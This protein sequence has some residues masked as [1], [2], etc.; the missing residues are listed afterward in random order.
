[1]D[2]STEGEIKANIARLT[3][4]LA[5]ICK[6]SDL[7]TRPADI[8]GV[9]K[10]QPVEKIRAAL[11]AGLRRFGENR[12]Q[13][14]KRHWQELRPEFPDVELHLIG[15]LQS[16]KAADAVALFDVIQT[17]DR[18]KIADAIAAECTRQGKAVRCMVQVNT[19]EEE[20]K[21]GVSPAEANALIRYCR[22][23]AKLDLIGLMCVPPVGEHPAPHFGLLYEIAWHNGLSE[24]SMGMSG[25]Y[26][27]AAQLGA[28][29]VRIG[30]KL[31]GERDY[32]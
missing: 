11:Q 30:T 16:N 2:G 18:E 20:Q 3:E 26:H 14:A 23:E 17:I 15:P 21:A 4:E 8:I 9:S 13:E 19:G 25:D 12:V 28:R 6:Q 32:N 7:A 10:G 24:L 31:F 1:M 22:D 27:I 5:R 29:Y